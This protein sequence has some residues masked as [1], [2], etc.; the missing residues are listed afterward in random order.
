MP[1]QGGTG[2]EV[3]TMTL[4]SIALLVFLA[5]MAACLIGVAAYLI[6]PLLRRLRPPLHTPQ[7]SEVGTLIQTP[8]E[9]GIDAALRM[10]P[11]QRE[12]FLNWLDDRWPRP[13]ASQGITPASGPS[14]PPAAETVSDGTP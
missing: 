13:P 11:A 1:P 9:A 8:L 6:A 7:A 10:T 14:L 2:R 12:A 3:R 4:I 5:V